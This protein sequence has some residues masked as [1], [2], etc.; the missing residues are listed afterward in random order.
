MYTTGVRRTHCPVPDLHARLPEGAHAPNCLV[1][2]LVVLLAIAVPAFADDT[3]VRGY[4]RRDGTYVR[5]HMRSAPD[6]NSYNNWSTKG[7][8]NPYTGQEETRTPTFGISGGGLG[9]GFGSGFGNSGG[10]GEY[11]YNGSRRR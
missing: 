4:T 8:V 3:Y 2:V 7:N 5:P 10:L 9:T 6:G 1:L 11:D